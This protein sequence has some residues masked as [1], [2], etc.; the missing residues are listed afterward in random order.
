VLPM[1]VRPS[2]TAALNLIRCQQAA[3][4]G[5]KGKPGGKR[6]GDHA[7]Q[8]REHIEPDGRSLVAHPDIH[9]LLAPQLLLA[10]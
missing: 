1:R 8:D 5:Q 3:A 7:H 2:E 6:D 9:K 4:A 10:H